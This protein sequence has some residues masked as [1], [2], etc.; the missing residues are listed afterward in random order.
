MNMYNNRC[1]EYILR[2]TETWRERERYLK[3]KNWEEVK[4]ELNKEIN[5]KV[6]LYVDM[7]IPCYTCN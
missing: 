4:T 7:L 6:Y 5:K 3:R 2:E 1:I